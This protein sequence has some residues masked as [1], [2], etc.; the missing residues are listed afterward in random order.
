MIHSIFA[1]FAISGL[2]YLVGTLIYKVAQGA[3]S[4]SD[5][6]KSD[7]EIERKFLVDLDKVP[8][9]AAKKVS[10][11]KQGYI[12]QDGG[13]AVRVRTSNDGAFL[14]TKAKTDNELTR[15]EV[16]FEISPANA[17]KLLKLSKGY[18]IEKRRYIVT[19]MGQDFEI[20]VFEGVNSG[21][22]LAELELSSAD[23]H[24]NL[25]DWITV[26]VSDDE[27]YFNSYLS[28]HPFCTWGK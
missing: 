17:I 14:T 13:T 16:E 26:E 25:P 15:E 24:V 20:D 22:V 6:E 23:Q 2:G 27:R 3:A 28:K 8:L 7:I 11:I 12:A 10:V 1:L 19:Y 18:M 21:L 4:K 5:K 9:H